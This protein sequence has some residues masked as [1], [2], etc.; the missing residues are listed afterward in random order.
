MQHTDPETQWGP[1]IQPVSDKRP[2]LSG[3]P[4][5]IRMQAVYINFKGVLRNDA[6]EN[7]DRSPHHHGWRCGRTLAYRWEVLQNDH[8]VQSENIQ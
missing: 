6:T 8:P 4:Q 5:N 7:Y 2:D 1:W 3:L